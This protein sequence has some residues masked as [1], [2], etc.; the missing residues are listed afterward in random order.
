MSLITAHRILIGTA[1]AFF[2]FFGLWEIA[3]FL[4]GRSE[5]VDLLQGLVAL[6]VA[7]AFGAYFP[8]IEKRYRK[9]S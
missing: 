4:R 3:G 7:G 1:I 5:T 6:I 8:T 9:K 2:V